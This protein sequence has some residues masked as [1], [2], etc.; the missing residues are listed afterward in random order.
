L[1]ILYVDDEPLAV[2]AVVRDLRTLEG[3]AITGL[4]CATEA[5][6]LV[7]QEPF[8]LVLSD[9]AM[10]DL[11]GV[12]LLAEVYKLRPDARRLLL[13]ASPDDPKVRAALQEG[14]VEV[15]LAKPATA[16]R[17]HEALGVG[18]K[19]RARVSPTR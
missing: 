4:T 8:D 3:V 15:V 17:L 13:T 9:F 2:R 7:R 16:E 11:D 10:P 5:V 18:S 12:D 14:L 19:P 6:D 1:R